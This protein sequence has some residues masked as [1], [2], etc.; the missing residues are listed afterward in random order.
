MKE[1]TKDYKTIIAPSILAANFLKLGDEIEKVEKAGAEY[2]H[3]DVMDGHFVPNISFG[4]PI[5][6][7]IK[8]NTSMVLDVHLMISKP[9]LYIGQFLEAGADIVNF[10]VEVEEDIKKNLNLIG[11]KNKS[12]LTIKPN[13]EIDTLFPF[14]GEIKMALIMTVEPGFGGQ[15]F[16][17]SQLYKIENLANYREKN[18]LKFDIQV[19]GGITESTASDVINAGANVL[20]AGS[21]IFNSEDVEGSIQN[22]KS[23][24]K[25]KSTGSAYVF[26]LVLMLSLFAVITPIFHLSMQ[27][28]VMQVDRDPAIRI[29]A[30]SGIDIAFS[31]IHFKEDPTEFIYEQEDLSVVVSRYVR[32]EDGVEVEDRYRI[33][34]T[35]NHITVYAVVARNDRV[36]EIIS[37]RETLPVTGP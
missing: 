19:D 1:N 3:I 28:A 20:V 30:E 27:N 15:K 7:S 23:I 35:A 12:A 9:S 6:Q 18:N 34:S 17:P 31:R 32:D 4:L 22:F 24:K 21:S 16:M 29:L 14:L 11:D 5:L 2:L 10:H 8:G 37:V 13:T 25:A 33:T 36:F 26:V